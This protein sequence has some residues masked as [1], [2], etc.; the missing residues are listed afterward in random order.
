MSS[1]Y[2]VEIDFENPACK[3]WD[4]VSQ[5]STHKAYKYHALCVKL[6]TL[7]LQDA[8][9]VLTACEILQL[10]SM[11]F[12]H[13]GPSYAEHPVLIFEIGNNNV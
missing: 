7:G 3:F 9:I 8:S 4:S 11:P 10:R 6:Y 13:D 12:W 1:L 2:R 5:R